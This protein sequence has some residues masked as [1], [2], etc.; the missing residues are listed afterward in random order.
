MI[1]IKRKSYLYKRIKQNV[2]PYSAYQACYNRLGKKVDK[3]NV[4][5]LKNKYQAYNNN[6]RSTRRLTNSILGKPRNNSRDSSINQNDTLITDDLQHA[7]IFDNY[8]S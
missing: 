1:I 4:V 6:I 2:I 5:Y 3:A 7:N 8:F